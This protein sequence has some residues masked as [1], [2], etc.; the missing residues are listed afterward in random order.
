MSVIRFCLADPRRF[1]ILWLAVWSLVL[2]FV[3]GVDKRRAARGRWRVPEK[4]LFLLALLGG[5]CGG[6]LAMR[7]FR[8]KTR[9]WYF[10]VVFPVLALLQ[11]ALC[12]WLYVKH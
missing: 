5:A 6:W 2:F 11:T 12:V 10:A 4:R 8:H 7:V 9:H 1:L 3:M